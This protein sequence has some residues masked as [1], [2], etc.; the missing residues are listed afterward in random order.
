MFG[1]KGYLAKGVN[2]VVTFID[3]KSTES[4][5]DWVMRLFL[6]LRPIS[7]SKQFFNSVTTWLMFGLLADDW[8][9]QAIA[10]ST[11]FQTELVSKSPF[12]LGPAMLL[13]SPLASMEFTHWIMWILSSW[14]LLMAGRP[15]IISNRTTPKLKTSLFSVSLFVVVYLQHKP[16]TV[17]TTCELNK[18][19]N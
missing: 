9:T 2:S 17:S 5:V 1:T 7:T 4:V 15:V 8:E 18:N 19:F 6:F 11:A 3:I 12:K 10:N 13:I 16:S 14:V